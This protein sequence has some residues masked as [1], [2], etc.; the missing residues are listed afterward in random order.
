[1][2]MLFPGKLCMFTEMSQMCAVP[3]KEINYIWKTKDNHKY[4]PINLLLPG[5]HQDQNMSPMSYEYYMHII[6]MK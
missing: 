4:E 2:E 6:P 1:M 5:S 3:V